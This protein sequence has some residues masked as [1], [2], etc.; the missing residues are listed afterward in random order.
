[1][2]LVLQIYCKILAANQIWV[3]ANGLPFVNI[4]YYQAIYFATN[5]QI[6][7]NVGWLSCVATSLGNV[8]TFNTDLTLT[9]HRWMLFLANLNPNTIKKSFKTARAE[10]FA[11][12][13]RFCQIWNAN[14]ITNI[15]LSIY[16]SLEIQCIE[17]LYVVV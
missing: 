9:R 17:L 5:F 1:M 7:Q 3:I 4:D 13:D 6:L 8:Q 2:F 10:L 12:A 14:F 15:H 16:F 11:L